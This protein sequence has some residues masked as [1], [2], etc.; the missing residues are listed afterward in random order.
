M[1]AWNLHIHSISMICILTI[2]LAASPVNSTTYYISTTGIDDPGRDGTTWQSAWATLSFASDRIPTGDHTIQLGPGTFIET[3]TAEPKTGVT[4]AGNGR[5]GPDQTR[6]IAS[7]DWVLAGTPA[8]NLAAD[9]LIHIHDADHVTIRD[10]EFRSDPSNLINGAIWCPYSPY[11]IVHDVNVIDFRLAG[12]YFYHCHHITIHHCHMENANL[13]QDPWWSGNL[14]TRWISD[15]EIH[16]NTF[17]SDISHGYGYKAGGHE[18]V[19]IYNNTFDILGEFAIESA[20]ENEYGVEIFNNYINRCISVPKSGQA[21][22]PNNRGYEYSFWIHDNVMTDS[23]TIEGP[24]NHLRLSRNFI[25]IEKT[26]GR[27]YSQHGGTNYG[28][29]WIHHNVVVNVD[30]AFIWKNDGLAENIFAWNNT[31]YC[32]D[33]QDRTAPVLDTWWADG[34]NNWVFQNN[35]VVAPISRPRALY[36]DGGGAGGKIIASHNVCRYIT[37]LPANNF[38]HDPELT[39]AGEKP[40]PYYAPA[41]PDS[42]VVDRGM[43]VGFPYQGTAPDIGAYEYDGQAVLTPPENIVLIPGA[44]GDTVFISWMDTSTNEDGFLIERRPYLRNGQAWTQV[45][46]L[47]AD[48][49]DYTDNM[50]IKGLVQYTYRIGAYQYE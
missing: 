8:D 11:V 43:D 49:T 3:T 36:Q 16:D 28:P 6:V 45:A 30:R 1:S 48:T 25:H 46:D 44:Y 27:C 12:M 15:S 22:N 35:V 32:A 31:I 13:Q 38:D 33:A 41:G 2:C 24:R 42:Y 19:K 39:H 18:N 21:D 10:I 50:H 14:R 17:L 9:Y 34:I 29:I 23:Y 37:G 47:P 4:I 26:G 40:H 7:P 5:N 20:H